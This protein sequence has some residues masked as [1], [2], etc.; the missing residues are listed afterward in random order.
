MSQFPAC[1]SCPPP[2]GVNLRE[3]PE[4]HR[5]QHFVSLTGT[6]ALGGAGA[7]FM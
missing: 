4:S 1:V 2:I 5:C 3:S 7:L 6:P